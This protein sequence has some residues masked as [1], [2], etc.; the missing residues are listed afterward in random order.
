M[1]RRGLRHHTRAVSRSNA[2]SL[3]GT[4]AADRLAGLTRRAVL[5]QLLGHGPGRGSSKLQARLGGAGDHLRRLRRAR[6]RFAEYSATADGP[7]DDLAKRWAD[8]LPTDF[9]EAQGQRPAR[10][11]GHTWRGQAS[12]K[13]NHNDKGRGKGRG[14]GRSRRKG[15]GRGRG[16]SGRGGRSGRIGSLPT[17]AMQHLVD[18]PLQQALGWEEGDS[19]GGESAA[20]E[21]KRKTTTKRKRKRKPSASRGRPAAKKPASSG[22]RTGV[23]S[24]NARNPRG[25][26]KLASD[27]TAGEAVTKTE[28]KR[29]R[30][31]RGG[32]SGTARRSGAKVARVGKLASDTALSKPGGA[33][34]RRKRRNLPGK[35]LSASELRDSL[36]SPYSVLLGV[37]LSKIMS[38][39]AFSTGF[40]VEDRALLV[41]LLPG[42]DMDASGAELLNLFVG[43]MHFKFSLSLFQQLLASGFFDPNHQA[44]IRSRRRRRPGWD[45]QKEKEYEEYWG[46]GRD[47][48]KPAD[49]EALAAYK[50]VDDGFLRLAQQRQ[51]QTALRRAMQQ[52]GTSTN[53][54][55]LLRM[56]RKVC[57]LV[58]STTALVCASRVPARV[59]RQL[60]FF[61]CVRPPPSRRADTRVRVLAELVSLPCGA[62]PAPAGVRA[63]HHG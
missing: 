4:L 7:D 23:K 52:R 41:S 38:L 35:K 14:R 17:Y 13:A 62:V 49:K 27:G 33:T 59:R 16:R 9:M 10:V 21:A 31:G 2:P 36:T 20:E 63:L 50:P 3:F 22:G 24:S 55:K 57:E 6:A 39:D 18:D 40:G 44:R 51:R 54:S 1:P 60:R 28:R 53:S 12:G 26:K 11:V 42:V 25:V 8:A 30:G 19:D 34:T 45:A 58:C 5:D 32:R 61:A 43:N 46:V 56:P 29:K 48:G 15:R 37:N 47:V